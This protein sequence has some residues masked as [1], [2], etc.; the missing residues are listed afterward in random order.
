MTEPNRVNWKSLYNKHI[1]AVWILQRKRNR[2]RER[3]CEREKEGEG[4]NIFLNLSSVFKIKLGIKMKSSMFT[5]RSVSSLFFSFHYCLV[6]IK[7][8][9]HKNHSSSVLNLLRHHGFWDKLMKLLSLYY[10]SA[11]AKLVCNS[12]L[13]IKDTI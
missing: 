10:L 5:K 1:W 12:V 4:S 3:V 8:L 9:I 13:E 2:K 6:K 11:F 7:R